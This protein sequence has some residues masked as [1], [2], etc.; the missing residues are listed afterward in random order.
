MQ[1]LSELTSP[2][3]NQKQFIA[4]QKLSFAW[5][6]KMLWQEINFT[7]GPGEVLCVTGK[8]G[9]GKTTLL[10]VIVGLLQP[11]SGNLK[12][13]DKDF[14]YLAS[15]HNG[16]FL[17]LNIFDNLKIDEKKLIDILR[18]WEFPQN[19]GLR[20]ISLRK[21][22]TGMKRKA[23]LLRVIHSQKKI[24]ILD[25]PVS[26]L[27]VVSVKKFEQAIIHHIQDGGSAILVSHQKLD[28]AKINVKEICLDRGKN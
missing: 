6:H 4:A 13:F 11:T 25:E 5:N 28:F 23:A 26:G 24:W 16:F 15:E 8:N 21:F 2:H 17:N 1:P 27:D 14:S 18:E 10:K 3:H 20:Q 19:D 22:S 12:F 9:S 7:C